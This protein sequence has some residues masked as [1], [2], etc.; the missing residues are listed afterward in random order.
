MYFRQNG[1]KFW[2]RQLLSEVYQ[3]QDKE[4]ENFVDVYARRGTTASRR[5]EDWN[6]ERVELKIARICP[7]RCKLWGPNIYQLYRVVGM[8][9]ESR[10]CDSQWGKLHRITDRKYLV[11]MHR[12]SINRVIGVDAVDPNWEHPSWWGRY[13]MNH[14]AWTFKNKG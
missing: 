8:R 11:S 2:D 4:G 6:S 10:R 12:E 5:F 1:I 3:K 13:C 14:D 7:C 9:L